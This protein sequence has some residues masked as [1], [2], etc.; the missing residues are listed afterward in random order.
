[1]LYCNMRASLKNHKIFLLIFLVFLIVKLFSLFIAHDIW[2][3]SAVYLGMGKYI[4]SSGNVGLWEGSRPLVWPLIL[5]FF[6][7]IGLD[8]V[9]FGK[10][11]VALFSLGILLLAYLIA[12][13]IFNKK[14]GI[15][16]ALFLAFS[17]TF[18]LFSNILHAEIPSTFFVLLGFYYF[19]RKKYSLSGLFLGIAFMTRFFQIFAFFPLA[20]ILF[21]L[22]IRKK[23]PY[24]DLFYFSLFFLIPVIPYFILNQFLYGNALHP[25]LLQSFMTKYTGWVFSQPFY[26]YFANLAKENILA[27]FS[28]IS[29]VFIFRKPSLNTLSLSLLFLFLFVP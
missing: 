16:S 14:I 10:L 18:F 8:A 1:M 19:L 23:V 15:I 25:F 28:V 11:F 12:L 24:S 2:W 13:D 26:F 5:G 7:R 4:Y 6:W 20:L 3:D 21:Y 29:L 27:L 9:F 17:Q 22:F